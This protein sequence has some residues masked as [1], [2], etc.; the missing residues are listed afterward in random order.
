MDDEFTTGLERE[1]I[2]ISMDGRSRVM[3]WLAII[4]PW[5]SY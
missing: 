5:I 4:V 2:K 1:G 3:D